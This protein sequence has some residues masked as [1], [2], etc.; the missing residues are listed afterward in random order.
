MDAQLGEEVMTTS[1]V[2][3]GPPGTGKTTTLTKCIEA[4]VQSGYRVTV[5]SYTKAAAKEIADRVAARTGVTDLVDARTVHSLAFGLGGCKM[6]STV[7]VRKLEDYSKRTGIPFSGRIITEDDDISTT[8]I[9]DQYMAIYNL[10]RSTLRN[11]DDVYYE[12]DRPGHG[13]EFDY[14]CQSYDEWKKAHGY[15]DFSDMLFRAV[16]VPYTTPVLVVDEAQDLSPAQWRLVYEWAARA[17][18]VYLAGDDDQAIYVWSGAKP[19]GMF[20][21]ETDFKAKRV[22]LDQSYRI[23]AEVHKLAHDIILPVNGRVDK[24][25]RPRSNIGIVDRYDAVA[26]VPI[27]ENE[28]TLILYRN[29]SLRRE[30]EDFLLA[31]GIPHVFDN[32]GRSVLQ[33]PL[34]DVARAWERGDSWSMLSQ[35]VRHSLR[36]IYS[37]KEYRDFEITGEW[38]FDPLRSGAQSWRLRSALADFRRR[39]GGQLP[40][41]DGI[42]IHLSSIHGA[43]GREADHVVLVNGMSGKTATGYENDKD[44]ERRVF[45]VGV[46]RA[47]ERLSIVTGEN[48]LEILL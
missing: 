35:P 3:Y 12:S 18:R 29:H 45:Y 13:V 21:F 28:D 2:F 41:P 43:K 22:V 11:Y 23:P 1:T 26:D 39:A 31:R 44:S 46:T 16:G 40:D 34:A 25:Y 30:I 38:P 47:R 48:A 42:R 32:G 20:D 9:G 19:S 17:D 7:D 27:K 14:F 36:R 15:Y 6:A 5:V 10:A 33:S 8:E 4:E 37:D 24:V